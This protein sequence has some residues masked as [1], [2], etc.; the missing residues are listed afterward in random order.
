MAG[1]E[2]GIQASIVARQRS[3]MSVNPSCDNRKSAVVCLSKSLSDRLSIGLILVAPLPINGAA[4][5][6]MLLHAGS[7]GP[8]LK[9]PAMKTGPE[10]R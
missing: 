10:D 5:S 1:D 4:R 2:R 9:S 6:E 8:R 7:S 3:V